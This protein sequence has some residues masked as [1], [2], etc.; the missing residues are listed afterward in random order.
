MSK[1][2]IHKADTRGHA[3]HGWLN[4]HHTFSFARYYNPERMG[5]GLLRVLNDDIV[6]PGMGFGTHPHDNME[7]V[8]IPLKGA[9]AHQD[10]TGTSEVI[11]TNEVQIMSAGSGLTHSE[12][13]A[14]K[15]EPVNFLQIWVF[16]K[17]QSIQPRYEQKAYKPEDRQ[18]KLQTVISPEKGSDA[19]WI[20]QDAWFTLGSLKAGFSEDYQLHKR[21]NGVYAFVLEGEVE[22][23]GEKLEKR[24][25]MGIS[26]ADW[27]SI[28]SSAD[29]ELL[30]IEIP[31]K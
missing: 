24:D 12:F 3:N 23:D 8:S 17:E 29:A 1:K 4:S 30:L 22:I 15:T 25:G 6:A 20:N 27:V 2:I 9:L 31:M 10:S 14:S 13:N 11:E 18:N 26:D 16:P 7:I 28:K 5:F 21:G 19:L